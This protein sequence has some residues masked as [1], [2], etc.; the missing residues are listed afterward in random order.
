MVTDTTSRFFPDV[1]YQNI[2]SPIFLL[3]SPKS[4]LSLPQLQRKHEGR[5]RKKGQDQR[6]RGRQERELGRPRCG[7]HCFFSK[8]DSRVVVSNAVDVVLHV[9]GEGNAIQTLVTH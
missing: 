4:E 5:K 6:G 2:R 3:L 8:G 7:P 1:S 9:H